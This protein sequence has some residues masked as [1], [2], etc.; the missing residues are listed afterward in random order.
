MGTPLAEGK[1]HRDFDGRQYLLEHGLSA[2]FALIKCLR[3]DR[4]GNLVYNKTARNFSPIMA[5]AARKT[6]VQAREVVGA[7]A[8]DPEVVVTPGIYV[9]RVV[10]VPEPLVESRLVA[11]G[12][13]YP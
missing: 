1:E 8:I 9:D 6:I 3:A 10:A 2:G 7:G 5:T 11:Q 13:S 4:Y 12:R